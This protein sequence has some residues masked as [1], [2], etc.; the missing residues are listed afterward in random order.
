MGYL[1]V[2]K[3]KKTKVHFWRWVF[4]NYGCFVCYNL[5]WGRRR[6]LSFRILSW[7]LSGLYF[8]GILQ[9]CCYWPCQKNKNSIL[10]NTLFRR[11]ALP[12]QQASFS[13][14]H[15]NIVHQSPFLKFPEP[16]LSDA[17]Y[18]SWKDFTQ[19]L[20]VIS[21]LKNCKKLKVHFWRW[22]FMNYGC[23]ICYNFEWERRRFAIF[24]WNLTALYFWG[25]L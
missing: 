13:I 20:W 10:L 14:N 12:T 3:L 17:Q 5:G 6:G 11:P 4:M 9:F 22:V 24:S 1:R 2:E 18:L 15:L 8:W 25:I 16:P 21:E 7:N 23:F 19:S